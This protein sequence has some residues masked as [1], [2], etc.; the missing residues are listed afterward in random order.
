METAKV[1]PA[2][3]TFP[4]GDPK[5]SVLQ[6]FPSAIPAET[7]D[8]VLM[9]DHVGP[10]RSAG[11][12]GPDAFEVPWHP[13]RGQLLVT[14]MTKGF[15]RHADS[16][17]HR[18]SVAAPAVQWLSAGSGIMHAEGGGTPQGEEYEGFQIWLN[19]P[20]ALKMGAPRYGTHGAGELP[21]LQ[22]GGGATARL[23]AGE[24]GGAKGPLASDADVAMVDFSVPEG[25]AVAHEVPPAHATVLAYCHGGAGRVGG[26]AVK[27]GEVALVGGGGGGALAVEG[28]A[29]GVRVLLFT[30]APL[31]QPIAWRGP[32]VMTTA[33]EI[34]T[35]VEEYG[36]GTLL[37]VRAP[38][39]FERAAAAPKKEL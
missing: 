32:F 26:A 27:R 9:L 28:G 23:I 10:K 17:G 16:L 38:W 25:G 19:I 37:K 39:D 6:A 8:P 5:F 14:Y 13:H 15:M 4:T 35:A 30:G 29:G 3:I 24:A 33:A 2:Q 12:L 18:E 7:A 34:R 11:L 31:K 21:L 22:L 20:S 1:L 36:A